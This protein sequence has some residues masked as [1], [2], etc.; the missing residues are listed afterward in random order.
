MRE[1]ENKNRIFRA[2]CGT[3]SRLGLSF[4]LHL[5][6]FD[7][8]C[9]PRKE[10]RKA[11]LDDSLRAPTYRDDLTILNTHFL[12]LVLSFCCVLTPLSL[13]LLCS[14]ALK[15]LCYMPIHREDL[16]TSPRLHVAPVKLHFLRVLPESGETT[17]GIVKI[18]RCA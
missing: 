3:G 6:N 4:L 14:P 2:S 5:S 11:M 16:K 18:L 1:A 15:L 8:H 13:K 7:P 9:S 12:L 17:P 10:G